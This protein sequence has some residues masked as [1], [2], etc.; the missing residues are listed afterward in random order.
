AQS[1]HGEMVLAAIGGAILFV[2]IL[3]FVI[4]AVGTRLRDYHPQKR[5]QFGFAPAMEGT[6]ET[7]AVL[8]RIPTWGAVAI[9]LA[10]LAYAGPLYQLLS[11]PHFLAP[12]MR[13]W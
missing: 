1:W 6:M 8:D 7:P 10:V 4:V 12:G 11:T 13:T 3:M 2:S 9:G 5:V